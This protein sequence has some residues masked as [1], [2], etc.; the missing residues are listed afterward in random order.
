MAELKSEVVRMFCCLFGA[1]TGFLAALKTATFTAGFRTR[2]DAKWCDLAYTL[3]V[4]MQDVS[5]VIHVIW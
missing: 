2:V 1:P 5:S 3:G 4:M